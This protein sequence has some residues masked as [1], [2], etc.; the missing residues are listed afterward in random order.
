MERPESETSPLPV[1]QR[2]F[3]KKNNLPE[4]QVNLA[5]NPFRGEIAAY[6]SGVSLVTM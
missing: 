1:S 5:R 3:P 2:F 6:A 4:G